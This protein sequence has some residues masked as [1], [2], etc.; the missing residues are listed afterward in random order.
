SVFATYRERRQRLLQTYHE[1][2]FELELDR[3][4]QGYAG[5][6]LSWFR[7]FNGRYR[8]DRRALKRRTYGG[9]GPDSRARGG[10]L[11]RDLVADKTR[12]EGQGGQR[13][14]ILG[15]YE[16]GM[17]TDWDAVDRA[18]RLA[19]E[20]IQLAPQLGCQGLPAR[21]VDALCATTPPAEK[22]RAAFKRL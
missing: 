21:L 11:G 15:R 5:P 14:K 9:L 1:S 19:S 22:I 16:N 20:A 10:A 12:L 4:A 18:T 3:I 17:D 6:Y 7:I 2:F 8:R 13:Q